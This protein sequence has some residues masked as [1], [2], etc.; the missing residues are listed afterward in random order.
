M[1]H[2]YLLY[3]AIL[4]KKNKYFNLYLLYQ[5][6]LAKKISIFILSLLKINK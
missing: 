4:A 6:I 1:L 5:A 3:Q 2:L